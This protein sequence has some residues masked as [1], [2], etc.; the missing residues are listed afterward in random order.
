MRRMRA[1]EIPPEVQ[2]WILDAAI[3][4]PNGATRSGGTSWWSI[5]RALRAR[6]SCSAALAAERDSRRLHRAEWNK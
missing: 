3:H 1:D 4:A 6:S 5:K 2:A